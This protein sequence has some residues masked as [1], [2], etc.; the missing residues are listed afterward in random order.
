MQTFCFPFTGP[1]ALQ[2]AAQEEVQRLLVA[3][4]LEGE[5]DGAELLLELLEEGDLLRAQHDEEDPALHGELEGGADE[6]VVLDLEEDLGLHEARL[7]QGIRREADRLVGEL[8]GIVLDP[9]FCHCPIVDR[10]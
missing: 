7:L 3:G 2:G 5:V 6:E 8:F 9:R 10:R 4:L 1:I